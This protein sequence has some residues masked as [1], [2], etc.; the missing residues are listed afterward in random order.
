MKLYVKVGGQAGF[1]FLALDSP[2]IP[3]GGNPSIL[4]KS[5]L[6]LISCC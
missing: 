2:L 5:K 1:V 3:F 4:K 6:S